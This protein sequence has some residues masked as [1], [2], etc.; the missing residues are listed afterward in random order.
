MTPQ[1]FREAVNRINAALLAF[2][3]RLHEIDGLGSGGD[4][5]PQPTPPEE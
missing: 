1:F 4:I 5:D 2:E 3:K